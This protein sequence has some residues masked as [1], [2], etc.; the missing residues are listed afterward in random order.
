MTS[1]TYSKGHTAGRRDANVDELRAEL[2]ALN[3]DSYDDADVIVAAYCGDLPDIAASAAAHR[4]IPDG[5]R[6]AWCAAYVDGATERYRET[7]RAW[8]VA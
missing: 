8:E 4:D 3:P 2:D 5:D 6:A 7:L 1:P